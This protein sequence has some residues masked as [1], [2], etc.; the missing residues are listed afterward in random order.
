MLHLFSFFANFLGEGIEGAG[1]GWDGVANQKLEEY[2]SDD[3]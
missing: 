3:F 2:S 1:W